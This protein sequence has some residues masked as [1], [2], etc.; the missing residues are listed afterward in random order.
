[1]K[2]YKPTYGIS[3]IYLMVQLLVCCIPLAIATDLLNPDGA[4]SFFWILLLVFYILIPLLFLM[5]D[6]ISAVIGLFSKKQVM[7]SEFAVTYGQKSIPLDHVRYLTLYLPELG[8]HHH[9]AQ[10][11][12]LYADSKQYLEI[13]RPSIG[14]ILAL[15][16]RCTQAVFDV[17]DWKGRIKA[18]FWIALGVLAVGLI[19]PHLDGL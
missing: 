1:M 16:K 2:T 17:D 11:L 18:C 15:K 10:C 13:Q 3:F 5:S 9:R 8:K 6:L 19:L 4:E 7:L 12:T 14:L